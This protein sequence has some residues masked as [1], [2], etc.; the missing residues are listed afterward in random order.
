[1]AALLAA[2]GALVSC[3]GAW[4][5]A[6][7]SDG[8]I[9]R[10]FSLGDNPYAGGQHRGIDVALGG[11]T[12]VR[13]PSAGEITFAGQV[14]T[15]GRTVSI[16][17]DDGHKASLTHVGLLLVR[18]GDRV[19]EGQPVADAGPSGDAEHSVPYVHLGVRVGDSD[20]YVDPVSLLPP[21]VAPSPPPA[22]A[23]APAP[24]VPAPAP[25]PAPTPLSE[26]PPAAA[27]SQPLAEPAP[28]VP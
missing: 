20:A 9:L 17:T 2:T 4:A 24:P 16:A 21:R 13:A 23:A 7:P 25:A 22:P 27:A 5:W 6:W 19:T 3:S 12:V 26:P 1:M 10:E 11:A 18:R 14:P 28:E 15:H 8:P